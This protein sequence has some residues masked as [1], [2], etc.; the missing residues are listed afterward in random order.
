MRLR[1]GVPIP[2]AAVIVN[3]PFPI[4]DG[5]QGIGNPHFGCFPLESA[6]N[7]ANIFPMAGLPLDSLEKQVEA[8][9]RAAL[10]ELAQDEAELS[11][12]ASKP[13]MDGAQGFAA[14]KQVTDALR[15][16]DQGLK[17]S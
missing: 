14:L 17:G 3:C 16:L 10:A 13:V 8:K 1:T 9:L 4:G 2:G 12:E 5:Q 15:R 6:F 11:A 7:F